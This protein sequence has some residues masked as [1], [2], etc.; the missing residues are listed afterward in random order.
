MFNFTG[1]TEIQYWFDT[2][3]GWFGWLTKIMLLFRHWCSL[4]NSISDWKVCRKISTRYAA[5]QTQVNRL[6]DYCLCTYERSTN[7]AS[8]QTFHHA[9]VSHTECKSVLL[10][11]SGHASPPPHHPFHPALG[12]HCVFITIKDSTPRL[13]IRPR[14]SAL[15]FPWHWSHYDRVIC[16]EFTQDF[17][18]GDSQKQN[19]TKSTRLT[20]PMQ[21]YAS[22]S[23][24]ATAIDDSLNM[25]ELNLSQGIKRRAGGFHSKVYRTAF[26]YLK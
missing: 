16:S 17:L 15:S 23:G 20:L 21:G 11:K 18:Q 7:L 9:P 3:P 13:A 19:Y 25:A 4:L 14:Y 5:N 1:V 26:I 2:R 12:P 22:L 10:L 6:R 8:P 24:T